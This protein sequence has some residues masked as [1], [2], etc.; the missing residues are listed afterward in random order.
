MRSAAGTGRLWAIILAAGEGRRL[1]AL[2]RAWHGQPRPKQ[3]ARLGSAR[4]MVQET[5]DRVAF[6]VPPE[7]TVVVVGESHELLARAQLGE[8]EGIDLVLQPRNLETGPGVLLP[9]ARILATDP[10]ATAAVFPSDHHVCKPGL[11][12]E[13]V[14][15]AAASSRSITF[16]R[17]TLLGIVPDDAE[18]EYGWILPGAEIDP[19]RAP[20]ICEVLGFVEKPRPPVARRL[21]ASGAL[22]NSFVFVGAVRTLWLTAETHLPEQAALFRRYL[23]NMGGPGERG[24]LRQL[25]AHMNAANF[26][27]DVLEKAQNLAVLPVEGTGWSDRGVPERAFANEAGCRT[28]HRSPCQATV[29]R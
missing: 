24:L 29:P 5:M 14:E 6:L 4:S 12:L 19:D 3:F 21:A 27:R 1:A 11:F 16:A 20:G 26:S 25:Y 8:Y 15:R 17:L 13:S 22:W 28:T 10:G 9:L 18:P 7:R 23:S 2:T